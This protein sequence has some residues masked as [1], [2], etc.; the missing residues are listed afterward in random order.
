MKDGRWLCT[1]KFPKSRL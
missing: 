1:I